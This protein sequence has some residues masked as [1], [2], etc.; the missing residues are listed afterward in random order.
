M[1]SVLYL[2]RNVCT[3]HRNPF[4]SCVKCPGEVSDAVSDLIFSQLMFSE[5][6][7]I[8]HPYSHTRFR[9][10]ASRVFV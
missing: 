10:P 2:Q 3:K 4:V 8:K 7:G 5:R 6:I 1:F 9:S